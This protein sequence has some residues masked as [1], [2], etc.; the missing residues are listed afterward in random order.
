MMAVR[1][2][3]K[4]TLKS[5]SA[6]SIGGAD[7]SITDVDIAL[8]SR[9]LPVIPA[10]SLC[11]AL[12]GLL[13]ET[14]ARK[15]FGDFDEG[16]SLVRVYDA[17][18]CGGNGTVSIR[19]SVSLDD[20]V[21]AP[22]LKFDR[23]VVERGTEFRTIIEI[24]DERACPHAIV[25]ELL[26]ALNA[27]E[28]R[29]GSK[30]TRGMGRMEVSHCERVTFDLAT[31]DGRTAWLVFSPFDDASWESCDVV[32]D[33]TERITC[34]DTSIDTAHL[35]LT[36][37]LAGGISVR[38]YT[39]EPESYDY[40]QMVVHG[41]LDGK[42][43]EV[44]LIPGTSWAGAFRD[45]Y[46]LLSSKQQTCKLFGTISGESPHASRIIFDESAVERGKWKTYTRNAIDR[47]TGGT[48][49]LYTQRASYGGTTELAIT[50]RNVDEITADDAMPLIATL[51]DLHNGFLSVGGLASVGHGLFRISDATLVVRGENHS[52]AF[53]KA[54]MRPSDVD[55]LIAPD[56]AEAAAILVGDANG[57]GDR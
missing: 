26:S 32:K 57:G 11:G 15:V 41:E 19:D 5:L 18:L 39:T 25:E 49:A 6:L 45:R 44:P 38:E 3:Y 33:V 50:V 9:D 14:S 2:Y 46:E 17:T 54:L 4:A 56:L 55:G 53:K 12:R 37:S 31:P 35:T 24:V 42:G 34:Q 21:A 20:R 28:V 51:A 16:E 47:F 30:R 43:N 52:E 8:D 1:T 10:T 48:T 23:E 29:L 27:G 40:S 22:G 7:S 13:D 36:L